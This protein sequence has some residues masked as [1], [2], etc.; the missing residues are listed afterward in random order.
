MSTSFLSK[1]IN[2]QHMPI[3]VLE[4]FGL[5]SG[6]EQ[7]MRCLRETL[8]GLMVPQVRSL[9]LAICLTSLEQNLQKGIQQAAV[10]QK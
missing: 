10:D 5:P 2:R 7:V 6:L 4:L 3:S 8:S 1:L 9:T